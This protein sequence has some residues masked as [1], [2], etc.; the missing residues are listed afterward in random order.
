MKIELEIPGA[1]LRRAKALAA[2]RG[3]LFRSHVLEALADNLRAQ[4]KNQEKPWMK[5][6]CRLL[7]VQL[8]CTTTGKLRHLHKETMKSDY[9][10]RIRPD[11]L[12][13]FSSLPS[14]I[15]ASAQQVYSSPH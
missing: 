7:V 14:P 10:E 2:S 6:F 5:L 3:I 11:R 8:N 1:I 12:I 13:D 15:D 4:S 9:S